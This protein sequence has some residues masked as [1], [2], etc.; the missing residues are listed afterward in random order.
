MY[1]KS[2]DYIGSPSSC[3][4]FWMLTRRLRY[5]QTNPKVHPHLGK[6]LL[7]CHLVS[8]ISIVDSGAKVSVW[9]D[10]DCH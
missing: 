4:L 6:V 9:I 3:F 2:K 5:P 1:N 10:A 8:I 7:C